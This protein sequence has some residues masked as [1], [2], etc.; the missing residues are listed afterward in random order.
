MRRWF[1]LIDNIHNE[2]KDYGNRPECLE[3]AERRV[4]L[5]KNGYWI[6]KTYHSPV[7]A[8]LIEN[9]NRYIVTYEGGITND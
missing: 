4:S 6:G 5:Y 7:K 8:V 9:E 3:E 1:T 2:I